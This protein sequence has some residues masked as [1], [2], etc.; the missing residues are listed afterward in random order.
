MKVIMMMAITADGKIAKD[1]TQ[2]ADWTSRE[3]K[4]LF[5]KTSKEC[6]AVLMGENTFKTFP[7]PL[8]ER[9]NVVFSENENNPEIEGVKFVKGEPEKVLAELEN[10]GYEKVLL[11]GGAFL[12]SL[13]LEKKLINEIMVTVEPKIFGAGLSLFNRDLDA[14]LKLLNVEKINEDTVLLHYQVLT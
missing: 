11:G 4:K 2:F 14:N 6:G 10:L 13:F 5:A 8:K 1:S 12:N 9:L 7:S 3:D